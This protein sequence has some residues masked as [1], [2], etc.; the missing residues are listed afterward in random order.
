MIIRR[1]V[2]I[3]PWIRP[4]LFFSHFTPKLAERAL[5]FVGI[6]FFFVSLHISQYFELKLVDFIYALQFNS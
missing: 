1:P 6:S 5:Y 2:V 3:L 4:K